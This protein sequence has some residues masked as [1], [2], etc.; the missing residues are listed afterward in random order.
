MPVP[1][2]LLAMKCMA[3]RIGGTADEPSDV[4][5]IT[6]LIRHLGFK[7]APEVLDLVCRYYPANRIPVKAQYLIE[8]L[9]DG[10]KV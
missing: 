3:A 8:S 6:Y 2:Y 1:E 10:G 7:S 5:D 9:F 4:A